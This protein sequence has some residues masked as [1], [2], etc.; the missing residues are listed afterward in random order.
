[1]ARTVESWK[2]ELAA[3]ESEINQLEALIAN[4]RGRAGH[5]APAY[6]DHCEDGVPD[7]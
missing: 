2:K 3:L 1:M 6:V 7:A 4:E 5:R